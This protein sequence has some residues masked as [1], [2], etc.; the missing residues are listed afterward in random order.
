MLGDSRADT[1]HGIGVNLHYVNFYRRHFTVLE[2]LLMTLSVCMLMVLCLH[3]CACLFIPE[4]F[5][6]A[7]VFLCSCLL[8]LSVCYTFHRDNDAKPVH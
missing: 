8:I 5:A 7:H 3:A 4:V 6:I 2:C 1:K